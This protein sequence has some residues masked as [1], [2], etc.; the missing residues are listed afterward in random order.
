MVEGSRIFDKETFAGKGSKRPLHDDVKNGLVKQI[1]G[2]SS[3]WSHCK[4]RGIIDHHGEEREV[5]IHWFEE[6]TV[7]KH[8][9]KIKKF[10]DE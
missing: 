2:T 8:R 5:E 3:E 4:G 9:F 1:G 10:L 6:P 7:G